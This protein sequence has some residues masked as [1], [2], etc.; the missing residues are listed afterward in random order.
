[1]GTDKFTHFDADGRAVMVDVTEKPSTA[2]RALARGSIR[3]A[4][5]TVHLIKETGLAKGDVIQVAELA[6]IMGAKRTSDLIPLCHPLPLSSVQVR[7][8]TDDA[9]PGQKVEAE[10]NPECT[11]LVDIV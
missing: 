10:Q 4:P 2:R 7:I 8:K 1:M 5:A 3:M 11:P 9:L 6:G